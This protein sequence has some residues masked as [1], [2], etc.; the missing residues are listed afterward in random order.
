MGGGAMALGESEDVR[1]RMSVG[2][3]PWAPKG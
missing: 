2:I 3:E 1:F